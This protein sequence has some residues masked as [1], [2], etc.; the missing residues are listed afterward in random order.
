MI[1]YKEYIKLSITE[2]SKKY[3][4]N[5]LYNIWLKYDT[6]QATL[7]YKLRKPEIVK[8]VYEILH[9]EDENELGRIAKI[10]FKEDKYL[11]E[12]A[13][14][15]LELQKKNLEYNNKIEEIID[16]IESDNEFKHRLL[17]RLKPIILDSIS[18]TPNLDLMW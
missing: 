10:H 6:Y 2:L 7:V 14:Q 5:E 18:W 1:H 12:E 15:K 16:K 9:S 17:R 3:K 4:K 13:K 11:E 8:K